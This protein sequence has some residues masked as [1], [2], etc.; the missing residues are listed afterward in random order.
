MREL[1]PEKTGSPFLCFYYLPVV[2]HPGVGHCDNSIPVGMSTDV[3]I[4]QVLFRR[5]YGE[6]SWS[7]IEDT[8]D[9]CSRHTAPLA[10]PV[11]PP[12]CLCSSLRLRCSTCGEDVSVS[13]DAWSVVLYILACGF[14]EWSLSATKRSSFD[15]V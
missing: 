13:S 11:S 12:Q 4:A 5:P 3:G 10:P 1:V 2:S 6:T 15:G 9:I 8:I 7:Y 14:L